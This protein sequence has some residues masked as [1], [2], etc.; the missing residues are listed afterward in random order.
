MIQTICTRILKKYCKM[1]CY[2]ERQS[3]HL[4][5]AEDSARF[6][7]ALFLLSSAAFGAAGRSP[8]LAMPPRAHTTLHRRTSSATN[9]TGRL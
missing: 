7:P 6:M 1:N 8:R 3:F 2:N 4:W 5:C 9:L